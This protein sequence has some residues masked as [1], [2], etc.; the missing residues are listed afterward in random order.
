MSPFY[1]EMCDVTTQ[2][3]PT[4]SVKSQTLLALTKFIEKC[5]DVHNKM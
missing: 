5:I 4:I 3:T 2:V 1:L